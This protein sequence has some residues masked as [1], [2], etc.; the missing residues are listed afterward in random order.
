METHVLDTE[1]HDS[2][3][4][5]DAERF[6]ANVSAKRWVPCTH[7]RLDPQTAIFLFWRS[8]FG[9]KKYVHAKSG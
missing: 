4:C 2:L 9:D 3:W 6:T 5:L 7:P 1:I 8:Q